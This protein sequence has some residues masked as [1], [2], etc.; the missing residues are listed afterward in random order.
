MLRTLSEEHGLDP[1]DHLYAEDFMDDGTAIRLK[2]TIN[3]ND[4]T[5]SL[6]SLSLSLS[7]LLAICFSV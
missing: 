1:I 2:I 5:S 6:L 7:S 3:R 4:V